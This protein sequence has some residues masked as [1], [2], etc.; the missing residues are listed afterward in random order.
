[1]SHQL[2]HDDPL[3]YKIALKGLFQEA[4][5]NGIEV[6]IKDNTVSLEN[7]IGEKANVLVS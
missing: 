4:K 5:E 3:Y 2:R 1:M 6:N 7:D